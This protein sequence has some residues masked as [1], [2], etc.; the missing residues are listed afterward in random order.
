[1]SRVVIEDRNCKIDIDELR[2]MGDLIIIKVIEREKT[3]GGILLAGSKA[4]EL[5]LGEVVRVGSGGVGRL[6][7]RYPIE[8]QPGDHVFTMGYIGERME[9]R[10]GEYRFVHDNG[11]WARVKCKDAASFD[12]A[13][14]EPRFGNLLVRPAD[15]TKTLSGALFLPNA[16]NAKSETRLGT[17][18]AVGPG[19]WNAET[20]A[21]QL[22][23]SKVGDGVLFVRYAGAAVSLNGEK[24]RILNETDIKSFTE[25]E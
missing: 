19:P 13:A 25:D 11:I 16:E 1:M 9:I 10:S 18:V 17:V 23:Q 20:G 3:T 24:L 8:L 14:I 6:G 12:F 4:T 21:R 5:C 7:R 2:P 22:M 15:E